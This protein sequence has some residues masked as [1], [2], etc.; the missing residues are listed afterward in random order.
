MRIFIRDCATA[1]LLAPNGKWTKNEKLALT[2]DQ[3]LRAWE[4]IDRLAL[5]GVQIV[6]RSGQEPREYSIPVAG[7][8]RAP[9]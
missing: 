7:C 9:A 3:S 4:E 2:F 1:K 8:Q 6:T 5:S